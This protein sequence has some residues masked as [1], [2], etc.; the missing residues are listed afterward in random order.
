MAKFIAYLAS[1][2]VAL[3]ELP[4]AKRRALYALDAKLS[5]DERAKLHAALERDLRDGRL[6]R[7]STHLARFLIAR[8]L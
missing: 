3:H 5:G 8:G 6:P 4:P 1:R 2:F 7:E